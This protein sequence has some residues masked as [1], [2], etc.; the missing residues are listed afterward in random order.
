MSFIVDTF[1]KV[2]ARWQC[3]SFFHCRFLGFVGV[4]KQH[5]YRPE[6]FDCNR[7]ARTFKNDISFRMKTDET[8]YKYIIRGMSMASGVMAKSM[9]NGCQGTNPRNILKSSGNYS[10]EKKS[11]EKSSAF[12]FRFIYFL[13]FCS[14][15]SNKFLF[16]FSKDFNTYTS[17]TNQNLLLII[18]KKISD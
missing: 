11:K 14:D 17:F 8:S 9:R 16:E 13:L 7:C 18:I 15:S 1:A 4:N 6:M 2:T 10:S 3:C 5:M 12:L